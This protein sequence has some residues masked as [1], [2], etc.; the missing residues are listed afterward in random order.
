M[1][2]LEKWDYMNNMRYNEAKCSISAI[3]DMCADSLRPYCAISILKRSPVTGGVQY[4]VG[5]DSGQSDLV[6][7]QPC[8]CQG[9]ETKWDLGYFPI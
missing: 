5:W 8:P 6:G 3:P 9:V 2:R 7:G 4:Q 1:D